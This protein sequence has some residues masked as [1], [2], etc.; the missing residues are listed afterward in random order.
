MSKGAVDFHKRAASFLLV[1]RPF[2]SFDAFDFL[3][4]I[5]LKIAI[6]PDAK[7]RVSFLGKPFGDLGG[8]AR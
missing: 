7:R 3:L 8:C 6:L 2:E 4:E 5:A 1:F